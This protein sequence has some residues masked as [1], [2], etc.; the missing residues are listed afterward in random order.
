MSKRVVVTG[1]GAITPI[2]NNV[3]EFWGALT[4]GTS[5]AGPITKWD[6]SR[7]KV[8]FACEVKNYDPLAHFD[9]KEVKRLEPF[10][11]FAAVA[12][13]QA[14]ADSGL[15]IAKVGA[16]NV[17]TLIASGIGGM[18]VM[19]EQTVVLMEK[20]P[21][22]VSPLLIPRLIPNMATGQVSILLGLKGPATCVV[23]ACAAG[24]HAIGD[25][26][27]FIQRGM[28]TAMIAGGTE[29]SITPLGV[30][31]FANMKALSERND[32]PLTASRPYSKDRDGF[33]IGEGAGVLML[34]DYDHAVARGAKIYAEVVGYG[35]TGDAHHITAPAEDGE[36]AQRAM[37][38]A[39]RTA[40]MTTNELDHINA[41]GT[42]TPLNDRMETVAVK[43]VFG[44]RAYK[45]PMCS[46][47]SSVGHLLGAAGGVEA[48]ASIMAIHNGLIPPT[49]N[50]TDRDP[51]CDLDYVTDGARKIS[52]ETVMSNSFGF[53]GHNASIIFRK[54]R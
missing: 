29:A 49:I 16:E 10:V 44:E 18:D 21:E 40:G 5:G 36:G 4:A 54:V 45:I 38:M 3:P 17:G 42:S 25:A 9:R 43:G 47:K 6:H 12:A 23:T 13:R 28:A 27:S 26:A 50:F 24:T 34:E 11:Q 30:A 53:G 22:R 15:D 32:S 51:D 2:G 19:E 37:R 39:L 8:H 14:L 7:H 1:L 48:I 52:V 31:G 33:V 46:N 35:L 20:G 41:H